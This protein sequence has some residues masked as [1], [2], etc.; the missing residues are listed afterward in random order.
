M[1]MGILGSGQAS[2]YLNAL[3]TEGPSRR[4]EWTWERPFGEG[5]MGLGWHQAAVGEKGRC[6]KLSRSLLSSGMLWTRK[7]S[8][9]IQF[10]RGNQ[11]E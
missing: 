11:R 7:K 4:S 10:K 5:V 2:G 6:I 1:R 9:S 3:D 8:I